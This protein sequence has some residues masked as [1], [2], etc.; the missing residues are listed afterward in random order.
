MVGEGAERGL[1]VLEL[2]QA[3]AGQGR[4]LLLDE[5]ANAGLAA[6]DR[7]LAGL[8]E[9]RVEALD[10]EGLAE[11]VTEDEVDEFGEGRAEAARVGGAQLDRPARPP[12]DR[13]TF[14]VGAAGFVSGHG[15]A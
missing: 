7:S 8:F 3:G 9:E 14:S 10:E 4:D 1:P 6:G 15:G 12:V 13:S 2:P 5:A 11:V